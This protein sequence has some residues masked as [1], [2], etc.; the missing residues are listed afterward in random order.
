MNNTTHYNKINIFDMEQI[1]DYGFFCDIEEPYT[2]DNYKKIIVKNNKIYKNTLHT[3]CEINNN[4]NK[5]SDSI[6]SNI[7]NT[8]DDDIKEVRKQLAIIVSILCVSIYII[9]IVV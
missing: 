4:N 1:S 5:S 6:L 3:I 9:M 7:S 2:N 8:I